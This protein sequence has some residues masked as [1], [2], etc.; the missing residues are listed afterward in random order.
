MKKA[1]VKEHK[2]PLSTSDKI[3]NVFNYLLFGIL[4]LIC[5]YPF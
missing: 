4:T 1:A 2:R 5:L 3:F